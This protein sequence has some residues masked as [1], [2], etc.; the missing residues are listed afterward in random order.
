MV[1]MNKFLIVSRVDKIGEFKK[2]STEYNMGFEFNDFYMSDVLT[3]EKKQDEIIKIYKEAGIP[4]GST[5]H[6]AFFDVL[7]FS[8]DEEIARLSEKR[9]RQ[10]LRI[11]KK[12]GVESVI[13]HTN[14]NPFLSSENYVKRTVNKTIEVFSE[15]LKEYPDIN[16]YLE[17]MFDDSPEIL[18]DISEGLKEYENYGVCFDYAHAVLSASPV[19]KW[20][21]VLS[22]Y[23]KHIHINDNDLKNDSHLAVGDGCIDWSKFKRYVD[24]Y[25]SDCTI[26]IE[27][28]TPEEQL[29]SI[30]FMKKL[31][32][33][34]D[35][36]CDNEVHQT[37]SRDDENDCKKI[38]S[39]DKNKI[40]LD[41]HNIISNKSKRDAE[42]L[43][44]EIFYY[45]T[46]LLEV[47]EFSKTVNLITD[48]GSAIVNADRAS[49]WFWDKENKQYWTL[50]AT[51]NEKIT[52]PENTG[53]VG[54]AISRGQ[55]ILCNDPYS[56]EY[57]ND[58]VDRKTGYLTKSI[59]CMPV[60]N[61]DGGVIGAF[62]VLNKLGDGV[63]NAEFTQKDVKR[64]SLVA[65]FCE[66]TLESYLL[67][68]EAMVD[69]LTGLKNRYAF[70]EYY[71]S[72]VLELSE[73]DDMSMVMCDIDHFKKV[74]DN[75]GHNSGDMV[76]RKVARILKENASV[77]DVVVRWGGEEFINILYGKDRDEAAE[78]AEK[79]RKQIEETLFETDM[80]PINITMSFGVHGID[81]NIS[82]EENV[83]LA[84]D[85]LYEAKRTGRNKVV[86]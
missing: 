58:E 35:K 55:V 48:L 45:M 72:K 1:K 61:T 85:K 9:L 62:Q 10:S 34:P 17:N 14:A 12:I 52:I 5:M 81:S 49:F 65:A 44:E 29:R 51:N 41:I 68:N 18:A 40:D 2:I 22:E 79:L 70:Y 25:F 28:N 20:V 15:L 59:L 39:S 31:G 43:L 63:S 8:I 64:L 71:N 6:G 46:E 66:K 21:R 38:I 50:A 36:T 27:T 24:K 86:S 37:D 13:F 73:I 60:E 26:L 80:E 78:Y 30:T 53:I 54:Q 67:Y 57:F 77:D 32:I 4:E 74:N 16:I 75:Y 3:D 11:A 82:S 83:K 42:E 23:I 33:I 19:D 76:L 7:V 56:Y 69:E 84:D 47:K